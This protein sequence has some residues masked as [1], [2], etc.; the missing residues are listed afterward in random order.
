MNKFLGIIAVLFILTIYFFVNYYI[1][2][3]IFQFV[4]HFFPKLNSTIFIIVFVII[5]L[6]L[7]LGY[8]PLPNNFRN[9]MITIGGYYMG[10]FVYLFL[11][12]ALGD[13]IIWL[14]KVTKLVSDSKRVNFRV[15]MNCVSLLVSVILVI[16]G[17]DHANTIKIKTYDINLNNSLNEEMKAVL[18]TDIHLGA[19]N[20]E[21]RLVKI[22]DNVNAANPDLVLVVGDTF[23]DDFNAIQDPNRASEL[24][25]SI[26]SKFGVYASLGNHDGGA[27]F[28]K[29]VQFYED[30]NVKLLKDEYVIIDNQFVLL[31][32]V[33]PSPI[34]GF[35]T[36]KRV[37]TNTLLELITP[38]NL[39]I[40]VMDHTP[41]NLD[42]YGTKVD[43]IVAGHTH[44]G[45]VFPAN[46]ITSISYVV[47]YGHYKEDDAHPDVIVTSGA[48]TWGMPMRVG[49][50]CE[51]VV[52]T[53]K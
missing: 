12:F 20:S 36:L 49:T 3:R 5:A 33:D 1:G 23:N 45:Q 31:G 13:L 43:L 15:M 7:V 34:G 16:Y 40:I 4:K 6:P 46:I 44:K 11:F 9:I 19:V 18:I 38:L 28:S 25:K 47:D 17:I 42:Q 24:F 51:I 35:D 30:S 26:N 14:G 21:S 50:D 37:E 41:S 53:L 39:P 52:I 48:G 8:C 10:I 22:I 29:M 2:K 27:T 32:R